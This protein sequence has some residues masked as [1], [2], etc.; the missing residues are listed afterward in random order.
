MTRDVR[1]GVYVMP[2]D[3]VSAVNQFIGYQIVHQIATFA[4]ITF[5][6]IVV[7]VAVTVLI[8]SATLRD[9]LW[10]AVLPLLITSAVSWIAKRLLR[11]A[12]EKNSGQ[13]PDNI[14]FVNLELFFVLFLKDT[15]FIL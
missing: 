2:C 14:R 15:Y 3:S 9:A 1:K 12:L 13:M 6:E 11:F 5:V 4:V 8:V 10:Q 7:T